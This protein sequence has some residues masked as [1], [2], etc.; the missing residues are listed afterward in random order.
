MTEMC[1]KIIAYCRHWLTSL[2][3]LRTQFSTVPVSWALPLRKQSD[4]TPDTT[5][6]EFCSDT[7][8]VVVHLGEDQTQREMQE[9]QHH[10]QQAAVMVDGECY[11]LHPEALEE[12]SQRMQTEHYT[13]GDCEDELFWEDEEEEEEEEI[14]PLQQPSNFLRMMIFTITWQFV[15]VGSYLAFMF[16]PLFNNNLAF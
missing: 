11:S 3:T 12:W 2:A 5:T 7:L 1:A 9:K 10:E 8:A 13:A 15:F 14:S 6:T 4:T 16:V